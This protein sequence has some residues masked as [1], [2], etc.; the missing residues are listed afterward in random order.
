MSGFAIWLTGLPASGKSTLAREVSERLGERD[1][2]LQVLDSDDLRDVLTPHPTYSDE[3]RDW[4]YQVMVYI[5]QLL[6]HNGVNVAFA[7]TAAKQ[8][9]RDHA[10]QTISHFAE[11][12]VQCSLEACMERD[13]KSLYVKAQSGEITTLPGLQTFYEAPE[14]A[15]MVVDTVSLSV[16]DSAREIIKWLNEAFL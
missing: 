6:T 13:P 2:H 10:R 4:F 12:Y 8:R 5:G 7:A 1:I 11:V 9:Y 3:E 15:E 16:A 14:N